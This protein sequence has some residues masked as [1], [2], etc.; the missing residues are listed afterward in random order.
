MSSEQIVQDLDFV[1]TATVPN[2]RGVIYSGVGSPNN[3]VSGANAGAIYVDIAGNQIWFCLTANTLSNYAWV[4]YGSVYT[5]SITVDD[6]TQ[7]GQLVGIFGAGAWSLS[8]NMIQSRSFAAAGGSQNAAYMSGGTAALAQITSE[9]F[10]GSTWT[11]SGNMTS[12]RNEFVGCGSQNAGVVAGNGTVGALNTSEL[13]NGSTWTASGNLTQSRS[14]SAGSGSQNA[15]FV[16]GSSTGAANTSELFNGSTWTASGNLT[17]SRNQ[18]IG[19]GS[20]NSGLIAGGGVSPENTSELFNGSTWTASGNLTQS[21]VNSISA[22][23]QNASL[24]AGS[25]VAGKNTSE[26]FNGSIWS[27]SGNLNVSRQ[28][29]AGTGAQNAGLIAGNGVGVANTTELHNQT[30]YRTL[31][32]K[33]Y[34]AAA[35][36]GIAVNVSSTANTASLIQGIF[37]SNIVSPYYQQSS[38]SSAI[39]YNNQFFGLT[40]FNNDTYP[41]VAS[42]ITNGQVGALSVTNTGNLQLTIATGNSLTNSWC[43][44]M[45]LNISNTGTGIASGNY[46]IVGGT[47]Y[48]NPIIKYTGTAPSGGENLLITP[49]H[50][51]LMYGFTSNIT[52]TTLNGLN[53]LNITLTN[54]G[55]M[56]ITAMSQMVRIGDIIQLPY[57]TTPATGSLWNYGSYQIQLLSTAGSV[58]TATVYQVRPLSLAENNVSNVSIMSQIV[59]NAVCLDDDSILLGLNSRMNVT[60][61]PGYSDGANGPV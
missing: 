38:L 60:G 44:G 11:A 51:K 23:S 1:S 35:S 48:T 5:S 45:L 14:L 27:L 43:Y 57:G 18:L 22:G 55:N 42:S 41:A 17:Q 28:D 32:Y 6:P 8:G 39:V 20:Q 2:V 50:G 16:A 61:N 21:R 47:S 54:N 26:L 4:P 31:T 37:P 58:M 13:F 15:S 3:V 30:T 36:V 25:S 10:N 40:K 52:T 12:S 56:S 34:P 33:D 59:H 49:L 29:S 24:V 9:L 7:E 19:C 53:A 46:P